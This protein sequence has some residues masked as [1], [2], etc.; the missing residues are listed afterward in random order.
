[1]DFS[2][3][4]ANFGLACIGSPISPGSSGSLQIGSYQTSVPLTE[5]NV[6]FV[7]RAILPNSSS[8]LSLNVL[9]GSTAASTAWTAG[10]AQVET[11]T[12][13]A[14]SGC[15]SNGT[16]TLVVTAAGLTGS[17]LNVAVTLTTAT[18]TTATLIATAARTALAANTAVAA[19]FTIGGT[20]AAITLTRLPTSTYTVPGGTLSIYA[21]NDATLN[22]AIPAGLGVTVSATSTN[23]TAGVLTTGAKIYGGDGLDAEGETLP[24]STKIRGA[25]LAVVTATDTADAIDWTSVGTTSVSPGETLQRARSTNYGLDIGTT[26]TFVPQTGPL[27]MTISIFGVQ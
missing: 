7:V 2:D 24:V 11:N 18:E 9:T 12:I 4:K 5:V 19:M 20:V 25:T 16:M 14:A 23:T 10:A 22:L 8:T 13:V 1:M 6:G 21:A 26:N 15:T 27:D 17:P 3:A